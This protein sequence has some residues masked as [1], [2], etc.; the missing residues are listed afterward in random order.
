MDKDFRSWYVPRYVETRRSTPDG[1]LGVLI[2]YPDGTITEDLLQF[3]LRPNQGSRQRKSSRFKSSPRDQIASILEDFNHAYPH[4]FG[5]TDREDD[6]RFNMRPHRGPRRRKEARITT[7]LDEIDRLFPDLSQPEAEEQEPHWPDP[8]SIPS[9]HDILRRLGRALAHFGH[10]KGR[11]FIEASCW[12]SMIRLRSLQASRRSAQAADDNPIETEIED[13]DQPSTATTTQGM[14]EEISFIARNEVLRYGKQKL[15]DSDGRFHAWKKGGGLAKSWKRHCQPFMP[16]RRQRRRLEQSH[17]NPRRNPRRSKAGRASGSCELLDVSEE[18]ASGE[19]FEGDTSDTD[20]EMLPYDGLF[21]QDDV[22]RFLGLLSLDDLIEFSDLV[23]VDKVAAFD[24]VLEFLD[25]GVSGGHLEQVSEAAHLYSSRDPINKLGRSARVP[26][27]P[28]PQSHRQQRK[29]PRRQTPS[30]APTQRTTPKAV[31]WP[32]MLSRLRKTLSYALESADRS[33]ALQVPSWLQEHE[34]RYAD[35]YLS[36]GKHQIPS[37]LMKL[38]PKLSS[39]CK[40]KRRGKR[41]IPR[42]KVPVF[43][44]C[45]AFLWWYQES[46]V[47]VGE[48]VDTALVLGDEFTRLVQETRTSSKGGNPDSAVEDLL[49]LQK[50]L[51]KL[52]KKTSKWKSSLEA[53]R[54]CFLLCNS[55]SEMVSELE[56]EM[57][58]SRRPCNHFGPWALIEGDSDYGEF[59]LRKGLEVGR[60]KRRDKQVVVVEA[61]RIDSFMTRSCVSGCRH[62]CMEMGLYLPHEW[63]E[64]YQRHIAWHV[65]RYTPAAYGDSSRAKSMSDEVVGNGSWT[66]VTRRR[67]R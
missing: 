21:T 53:L 11:P 33:E 12:K 63:A 28:A 38:A 4:L 23:S 67:R 14:Q 42:L 27:A 59:E 22:K 36:P 29:F 5:G 66:T 49:K 31:P 54:H 2:F 55:L 52:E 51:S 9:T 39:S 58:N 10:G 46:C 1:K 43:Q 61:E 44:K 35:A 65:N 64:R 50:G 34:R 57:Y 17:I 40:G 47:M 24:K 32:A 25:H 60:L 41:G 62:C 16:P 48:D 26:A 37:D 8:F 20:N 45:V 13:G 56:I 18:E 15:V 3:D 6:V 7:I 19:E 30:K